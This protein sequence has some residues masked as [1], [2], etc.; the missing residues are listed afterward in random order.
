MKN[1][2]AISDQIQGSNDQHNIALSSSLEGYRAEAGR[3]GT[4]HNQLA[5]LRLH[6]SHRSDFQSTAP[7]VALDINI[8]HDSIVQ[9]TTFGKLTEALAVCCYLSPPWYSGYS[10]IVAVA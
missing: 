2:Q 3:G 1:L 4:S 9:S 8:D 7:V 6:L 5:K 10:S